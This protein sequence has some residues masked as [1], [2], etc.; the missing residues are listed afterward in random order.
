MAWISDQRIRVTTN[1][2]AHTSL[3]VWALVLADIQFYEQM[4]NNTSAYLVPLSASLYRPPP[5]A[6]HMRH[7]SHMQSL[8]RSTQAATERRNSFYVVI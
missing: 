1:K 6:A 2:K 4:S 5:D 8:T 7:P 3:K